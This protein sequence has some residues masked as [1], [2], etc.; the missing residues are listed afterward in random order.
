MTNDQKTFANF[1]ISG[2]TPKDAALLTWTSISEKTAYNKSK[3]LM[4]KEGIIAYIREKG[5]IIDQK[6]SE[7]L[8]T[9]ITKEKVSQLMSSAMKRSI[10]AQIISGKYR[11]E[12]TIMVDGKRKKVKMK[13]DLNDIMKAI[14]I[15]NKMSGDLILA[16]PNEIAK[17]EKVTKIIV[18]E[19]QTKPNGGNDHN[20]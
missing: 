11:I 4:K 6:V 12:K 15:D 13:P 5:E 10:L 14:E 19:D 18:V 9:Q 16:K 7:S 20:K 1:V 17:A 8:T 3:I 2:K